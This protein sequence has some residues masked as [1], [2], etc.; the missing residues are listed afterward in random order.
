MEEDRPVSPTL[1]HVRSLGWSA[2]SAQKREWR[3]RRRVLRGV[4]DVLGTGEMRVRSLAMPWCRCE[5]LVLKGDVS[6]RRFCDVRSAEGE[7]NVLRISR[8]NHGAARFAS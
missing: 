3:E 2:Y 6:P 8:S 5:L 4:A 1:A 7:P